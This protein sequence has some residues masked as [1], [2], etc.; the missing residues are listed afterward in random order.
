MTRDAPETGMDDGGEKQD[1]PVGDSG[2]VAEDWSLADPVLDLWYRRAREA[3]FAHYAAAG[4]CTVAAR[5]LGVPTVVLS[6]AAGTV[7]FASLQEDTTPPELR[8]GVGLISV[9]AAVLAALQTFLGFGEQA[10]KHRLAASAYG[11][12]R[13]EIEECR[14]LGSSERAP[15]AASVTEIRRKLDDVA[16]A[17]PEVPERSW[18]RAQRSM[19]VRD[20]G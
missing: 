3:Q 12:I 14:A 7:L 18:T 11:A 8:L 17:S 9:C 16:S 6:G 13:R 4:R 15:V 1:E 20:R 19:A 5:W 2:A 10:D